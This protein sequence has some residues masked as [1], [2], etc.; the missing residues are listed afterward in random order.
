MAI[1]LYVHVPSYVKCMK[2]T[3]AYKILDSSLLKRGH[4]NRVNM[5]GLG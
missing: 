1:I 3:N 5:V 4:L 2:E